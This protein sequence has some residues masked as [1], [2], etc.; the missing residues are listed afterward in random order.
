M[1][2]RLAH[3]S[4]EAEDENYRLR[5]VLG[6]STILDIGASFDQLDRLGE[7]IDR[8]LDTDQDLLPPE[9]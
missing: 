6:D 4:I 1:T 2:A 7:E 3:F 9:L 5:L 8:R